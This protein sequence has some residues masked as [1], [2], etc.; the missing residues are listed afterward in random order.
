MCGTIGRLIIRVHLLAFT[1][2]F[3]VEAT[4][5]CHSVVLLT[6]TLILK[7][8]LFTLLNVFTNT[9]SKWQMS[10]VTGQ[11]SMPVHLAWGN[12]DLYT[13]YLKWNMIFNVTSVLFLLNHYE[14]YDRWLVCRLLQDEDG[15]FLKQHITWFQTNTI[16]RWHIYNSQHHS[17]KSP[18]TYYE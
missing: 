8:F 10:V 17:L 16:G 11:G 12:L 6:Q 5:T 14:H 1:G 13:V 15:H 18:L 3:P 9:C 7:N 4:D 2:M